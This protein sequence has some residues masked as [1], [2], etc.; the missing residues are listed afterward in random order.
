M[1]YIFPVS[2]YF[3]NI[4]MFLS[5]LMD[6][7]A[8]EIFCFSSRCTSFL[9]S[10]SYAI[11]AF[12]AYALLSSSVFLPLLA[13][14]FVFIRLH[15]KPW[16]RFLKYKKRKMDTGSYNRIER[17]I[18]HKDGTLLSVP[19]GPVPNLILAV[20]SLPGVCYR[21]A[22]VRSPLRFSGRGAL[23]SSVSPQFPQFPAVTAAGIR[24]GL[25]KNCVKN[26][27]PPFDWLCK[28]SANWGVLFNREVMI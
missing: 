18:R 22:G 24:K 19:E 6:N 9:L 8:S 14:C 23:D 2:M 13:V 12:N 20:L 3:S 17:F 21:R 7:W 11:A 15:Y 27:L 5:I 26:I 4:L 16:E 10:C 28:L 1:K 25:F